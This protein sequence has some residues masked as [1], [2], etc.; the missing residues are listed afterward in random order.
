[1]PRNWER[2][3]QEDEIYRSEHD[4]QSAAYQLVTEQVL[5][6][7]DRRQRTA[8]HVINRHRSA[9]KEA[10]ALLGLELF[11]NDD[12]RYC[13][14]VPR[15]VRMTPLPVQDTLLI[16][17]MRMMFHDRAVRGELDMG[18]AIVSIEDLMATYKGKTGRELPSSAG[19]LREALDSLRRCGLARA[20]EAEEGSEQPFDIA[21]LPAIAELVN[22]AAASR[23]AGFLEASA[24]PAEEERREE[25]ENEAP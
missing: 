7:S 5:Y 19:E 17:V 15:D 11:F 2:Y 25:L 14:A 18:R 10:M 16:L 22:E 8:Y 9:F 4:Y 1:M 13:A 20:I 21:I 3:A 24:A 23:L 6:E 12:Y